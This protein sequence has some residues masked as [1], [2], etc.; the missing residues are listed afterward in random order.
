MRRAVD[1]ICFVIGTTITIYAI[2]NFDVG[3]R[4]SHGGDVIPYYYYNDETQA[5][6][7]IGVFLICLGFFLKSW[8]IVDKKSN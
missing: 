6:I 5:G 4:R 2:F 1:F 3:P 7:A 8:W